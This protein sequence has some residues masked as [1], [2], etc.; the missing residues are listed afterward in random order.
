MFSRPPLTRRQL[1]VPALQHQ[2]RED[3]EDLAAALYPIVGKMITG[4]IREAIDNLVQQIDEKTRKIT[5]SP[6][7]LIKRSLGLNKQERAQKL[8]R[9]N[10]PYMI[11]HVFLIQTDSGLLVKAYDKS[12]DTIADADII[13]G[14]LTAIGNFVQ[15]SFGADENELDAIKYGDH[16][17]LI[18]PGNHVYI[19]AV[20]EG[21]EPSD[22]RSRMRDVVSEIN[23]LFDAELSAF[24]GDVSTLPNF[25]GWVQPLFATE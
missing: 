9:D 7:D 15:D 23:V 8:L 10:L 3:R 5:Q 13:S 17:I 2:I 20:V 12:A 16:R 14:M 24:H 11:E 21:I 22:F 19:V 6:I 4:A 25:D 1:L 18:E